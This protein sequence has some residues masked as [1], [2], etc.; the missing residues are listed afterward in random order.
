MASS[1]AATAAR[2]PAPPGAA[3]R[4]RSEGERAA[5]HPPPPQTG[6]APATA[7]WLGVAE[8]PLHLLAPASAAQPATCL[9]PLPT[10]LPATIATLFHR[11]EQVFH[12]GYQCPA[13]R[14]CLGL[15]LQDKRGQ[16]PLASAMVHVGACAPDSFRADIA[17]IELVQDVDVH[18]PGYFISFTREEGRLRQG[19]RPDS[20]KPVQPPLRESG[21]PS[22]SR[23]AGRER[24]RERSAGRPRPGDRSPAR[25]ISS[26]STTRGLTTVVTASGGLP[27]APTPPRTSSPTGRGRPTSWFSRTF[28]GGRALA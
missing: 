16:V 14:E 24:G 9:P 19:W 26:T 11:L 22:R 27:P 10:G 1:A 25:S 8:A 7:V 13:I 4:S 2:A 3:R 21:S 17:K 15:V 20:A 18:T 12:H 6:P 23:S 5:P 28:T